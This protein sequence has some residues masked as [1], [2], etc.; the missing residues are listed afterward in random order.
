MAAFF[1]VILGLAVSLMHTGFAPMAHH[2]AAAPS[3][4]APAT[5]SHDAIAPKADAR[6]SVGVDKPT[7]DVIH[8]HQAH[9][10]AGTVAQHKPFGAP[11]LVAI[12]SVLDRIGTVEPRDRAALARGPPPWTVLT[13]T[14]LCLLRV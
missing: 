2:P 3:S 9:D 12:I 14:E 11:S 13:L 8:D 7:V 10:C 5:A 4:S 6:H 1:A